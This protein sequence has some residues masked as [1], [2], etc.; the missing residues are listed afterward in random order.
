M[1]LFDFQAR[2][3]FDTGATRSLISEIFATKVGLP[4]EQLLNPLIIESLAG[5]R[6]KLESMC[7]NCILNFE[8]KDMVDNLIIFPITYFH[9]II[10]MDW[11]SK[12]QAI[13]NCHNKTISLAI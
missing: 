8:G 12:Y 9:I 4:I 3:L 11:I 5:G 2:I 13:L 6:T 1:F 7:R 10:A